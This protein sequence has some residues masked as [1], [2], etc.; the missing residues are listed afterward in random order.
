MRQITLGTTGITV[1]QNAFGCLPIQRVSKEEAVHLLR[2]AYTGGMRF[3]DTARAYSDSE[4]KVGAAF[5]PGSLPDGGAIRDHIFL[6]T[7]TAAKTPEAFWK[8][9]ETS[10]AELQTD[11]IDVYQFHQAAQCYRP[12]DGTGMYECMQEAK[13][14]GKI[15][16]IGVTAHKIGVARECASS[17]LYETLQFPFSYLSGSQEQELVQLCRENGVGF[18]AMKGLAGGLINKSEAAYAFM[19]EQEGVLPIW[20][21]QR[22]KELDEWLSFFDRKEPVMTDGIRAFIEQEKTELAGDFC[23]GCGYCMPCPAGIEINN[24]ARMSLMLRRAPSAAWLTKEWQEKMNRIDQCL[25]CRQCTKKCPYELNTPEL[26]KK[27][28]ADYRR[29]LAGE[30]SV[31]Q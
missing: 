3:F 6:A 20:G 14:Q 11:H 16:H 30:V 15:R 9:L 13:A 29:V 10:L 24:C 23:R 7:K 25:G 5:G 12:G 1:P 21:I 27:N 26:L 22:E 18:I 4:E 17:G 2:R 19:E 8:D 31:G 28:L